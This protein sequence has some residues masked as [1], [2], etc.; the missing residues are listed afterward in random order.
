MTAVSDPTIVDTSNEAEPVDIAAFSRAAERAFGAVTQGTA[1]DDQ[2]EA[3][4]SDALTA[5]AS[6]NRASKIA[7]RKWLAKLGHDAVMSE[8]AKL[9]RVIFTTR[10]R[11]TKR[12]G[13]AAAPLRLRRAVPNP[14]E[15]LTALAL[16]YS[17]AVSDLATKAADGVDDIPA[18]AQERATSALTEELQ[19]NAQRYRRWLEA[20]QD[21]EEPDVSE[22][23]KA[24][25]RLS[26]GRSARGVGRKPKTKAAPA[27]GASA[28]V[29]AAGDFDAVANQGATE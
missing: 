29:A 20:G 25:A 23:A 5:Y 27:G 12:T 2:V 6:L 14:V 9:A 17:V 26:L 16:A 11:I 13:P 3:L 8:N 21:D 15:H 24:G 10:D 28:P 18:D 1:D 19:A 4:L 7:A 22:V